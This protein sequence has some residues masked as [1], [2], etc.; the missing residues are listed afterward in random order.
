MLS[1]V[2]LTIAGLLAGGLN[3]VAGGGT[4]LSFPALVWL[5][6]PPIMANAT[7]TL[8]AMPGYIGSAWAYRH[9][10]VAEGTL[11]LRAIILVAI[12]GGLAGAA[13]LLVTPGEAFVGIVPWLLL[14]ATCLFAAGPQ[15][16]AAVRAGGRRA[17]GPL[18]SAAAIFGVSTYGGYFNGGLG[19]M[20]LAVLGLIGFTN[21]HGMNG[22][23]NLLSAI[24]SIVSVATYA[25]AGL[26]AWDSALVLAV[27][28]TVGGY[29]GASQARRIQ[30][31]DLLRTGIVAIGVI[32]T[33]IFF[34]V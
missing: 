27:A 20:L 24:L 7:A 13:L 9:D 32:M 25:T 26:I 34:A 11:R 4:F 5:G 30:R 22:L 17:A 1:L 2:I 8:T 23:K 15:V 14:S 6:V 29:V 28:T 18:L 31:T 19:I 33:V 10:V 12:V 3:A 16:L 21:L